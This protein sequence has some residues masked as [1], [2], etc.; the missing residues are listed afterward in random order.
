[1]KPEQIVLEVLTAISNSPWE[2][3]GNF[4][5]LTRDELFQF[6]LASREGVE[7]MTQADWYLMV[8]FDSAY[9]IAH[10]E[11]VRALQQDE[12]C[13]HCGG[14]RYPICLDCD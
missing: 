3:K 9:E 11:V 2:F 5:H 10:Y 6:L 1:M 7:L 12:I 14:Q 13:K 8:R 4:N